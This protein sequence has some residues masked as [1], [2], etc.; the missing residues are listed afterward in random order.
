MSRRSRGSAAAG[1]A[2][3]TASPRRSPSRGMSTPP[4][5]A[6]AIATPRA[7]P[8]WRQPETA[9]RR[10]VTCP[11]GLPPSR[12]Q[13]ADHAAP[14]LRAV[15]VARPRP[16]PSMLVVPTR[17]LRRRVGAVAAD[18]GEY[19]RP[20]RCVFIRGTAPARRVLRCGH[21][22]ARRV[23]PGDIESSRLLYARSRAARAAPCPF[24]FCTVRKEERPRS[25]SATRCM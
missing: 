23:Q 2:T 3:S 22:G 13:A 18:N 24:G 20:R 14:S 10:G 12:R 5:A 1:G 7:Q 15:A 11:A 19:T 8:T 17:Q 6:V 9:R 21:V 25:G 4:R 16:A